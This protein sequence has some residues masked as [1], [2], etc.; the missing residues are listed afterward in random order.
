MDRYMGRE[1]TCK[2]T[3]L[4]SI[5]FLI[6]SFIAGPAYSAAGT[7]PLN[8]IYTGAIGAELEPCGCSP[9]TV[10]GGL[11]R[12]SGFIK[13][14]K[15]D[16]APYLLVDAGG[17]MGDDTPQGRLK[18]EALARSFSIIGYDSVAL[19]G[20]DL[21][22]PSDLIAGLVKKHN[23]PALAN[24]AP[25]DSAIHAKKGT[26]RINISTDPE[27]LKKGFLNILLTEVPSDKAGSVAAKGWDVI[28]SSSGE[29]LE[30]PL[31][32]DG[33]IVIAGYPKG[34]KLGIL[35]LDINEKGKIISFRQRW[36][37][38]DKDITEDAA[39]RSV[40]NDYDAKVA[41]LAIDEEKKLAS[42]GPYIGAA[43][44]VECH[45]PFM[46]GWNKTRHS[47][48]FAS[49]EKVGKSKDP[50]CVKCHVTGYADE[51]GFYS[52]KLTPGLANVQCEACHGPGREHIID[53]ANPMRPIEEPTCLRC[54]TKE[55]SPGFNYMIYREK[56]KHDQGETR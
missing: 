24:S 21:K 53:F 54:H 47:N 28:I 12:L 3:A 40:L 13:A 8:I 17:S 46:E 38:L 51:G 4:L 52:A 6:L 45:R 9:K 34:K 2:N 31:K 15:V 16:L 35:T 10:A 29:T 43:G 41:E 18:A 44:C 49:L 7:K 37:P 14:N 39:V 48:A 25:Y 50:E 22:L 32:K 1:T 55:N 30:E 33:M 20:K 11:A 42:G 26:L 56:I 5:A 23:I 19:T 27:A 36:Q